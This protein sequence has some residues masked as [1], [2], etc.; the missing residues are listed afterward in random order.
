MWFVCGS[1]RNGPNS[2]DRGKHEQVR[3]Y[4]RIGILQRIMNPAKTAATQ[5]FPFQVLVPEGTSTRITNA[6][7][8]RET[9]PLGG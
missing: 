1:P 2:P 8:V 4:N 5:L 6:M 7:R 9:K 3:I